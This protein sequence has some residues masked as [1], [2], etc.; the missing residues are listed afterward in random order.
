MPTC[1][2]L[3]D[4]FHWLV[5]KNIYDRIQDFFNGFNRACPLIDKNVKLKML[6]D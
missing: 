6:T 4:F 3:L 5:L 1:K 2:F